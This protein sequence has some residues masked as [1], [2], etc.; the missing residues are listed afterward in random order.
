MR[1]LSLVLLCLI[2]F[3]GTAR[4]HARLESASP[5]VGG[6]VPTPPEQVA[7]TFSEKVEPAFSTIE[8]TDATGQRADTGKPHRAPDNPRVLIVDLRPIGPGSYKV[9]W[10]AVSV[11][12]HRTQGSYRFTVAR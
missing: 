12:T 6:T 8:V 11:D 9:V 1:K 2:V 7:V 3:A 5:A 4:A 10:R